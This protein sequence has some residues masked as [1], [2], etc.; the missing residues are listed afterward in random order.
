MQDTPEDGPVG[1]LEPTDPG[2]LSDNFLL[3]TVDSEV[4]SALEG[5]CH[6]VRAA[7]GM[8]IFDRT[9]TR[10]D[11]YFIVSGSVRVLDHSKSGQEVAFSDI[12]AG[13]VFGEL[14]AIDN[15][16]RSAT[17]YALEETILAYVPGDA[18]VDFLSR[19]PAMAHRMMT[20]FVRT[21]RT[22]NSRV[23]GL[24]SMTN[25]QRVY[26]EILNMAEPDPES[27]GNWMINT[28][29]QHMEI[30]VWAGTTPDTVA[31]SIGQLL[32]VQIAKR[33]NKT[34]YIMDRQRLKDLIQA[35]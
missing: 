3:Q 11:V 13:E 17:V 6:W 34:L 15:A 24:S 7:E 19:Y 27:A 14:S 32:K 31:R 20:H 1:T 30:A 22:L 5:V 25:V 35:S 23:V 8:Q 33:R 18:F 29:P 28:M 26:S 10:T 4:V 9:D 16:A 21:I 12:L 2:S